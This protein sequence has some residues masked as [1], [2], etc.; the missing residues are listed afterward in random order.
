MVHPAVTRLILACGL[1]IVVLGLTLLQA[2]ARADS[3]PAASQ[4][5]SSGKRWVTFDFAGSNHSGDIQ[6]GQPLELSITLG[7]VAQGHAPLVAICESSHFQLQVVTFTPDP[8]SMVMK[9]TTTLEPVPP[10][11]LSVNPN[12]SR[13]QFTFARSNEK[14]FERIMT[15]IVYVTLEPPEPP[16]PDKEPSPLDQNES[17]ASDLATDQAEPLPDAIPLASGPVIEEDLLPPPSAEQP[18]TYWHRV[19][20]LVSRSWSHAVRRVRHSPSS[21]TVH[22]RFRLYP[23]GRAQLIQ[24]EK[25]SGAREIDTAGIHAILHAQPFPVFP[26]DLGSEPIDVHVLMK[27]GAKGGQGSRAVINPQK[28]RPTSRSLKK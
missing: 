17:S 10:T 21:E 25:G 13:L 28:P 7:G 16:S 23:G 11:R 6:L 1:P 14:K 20:H 9:A 4:A 12:I 24:I 26:Q 5:F 8:S 15:R 3:R 19:S 27:T 18:Q 2:D 22:V